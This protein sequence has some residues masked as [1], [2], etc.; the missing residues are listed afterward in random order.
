MRLFIPM[1]GHLPAILLVLDRAAEVGP[2]AFG[3]LPINSA[4]VWFS[5]T[6]RPSEFQCESCPNRRS[7]TLLVQVDLGSTP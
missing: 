4:I 2:V 3:K 6:V 7:G 5:S 1:L